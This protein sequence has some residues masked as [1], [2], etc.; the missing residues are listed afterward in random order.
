MGCG[1]TVANNRHNL[2]KPLDEIWSLYFAPCTEDK[3][4]V[5][6]VEQ[7]HKAVKVL[8]I[9]KLIE[10]TY[11]RNVLET[12]KQEIRDIL[13]QI[14]EQFSPNLIMCPSLHDLHQDHRAVAEC[15][16]TIFRD[17][18]LLGY[19][20]FASCPDFTPNVFV[21]LSQADVHLKLK[22]IK[23]YESQMAARG[24]WCRPDA[25]LANLQFRGA[26]ARVEYAEAFELIRAV[27]R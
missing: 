2:S 26:Q 17:T 7:H 9:D 20:T 6:H 3:R 27:I 11:R 19:E 22:A 4:N 16:T 15:C 1:G 14:K 21:R 10:R 5:N 8:G 24:T 18:T 25:F 12:C 13:W 23:C